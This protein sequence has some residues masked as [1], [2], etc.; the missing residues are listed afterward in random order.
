MEAAYDSQGYVF[1]WHSL[2][3]TVVLLG[4]PNGNDLSSRQLKGV[5]AGWATIAIWMKGL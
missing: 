2:V 5:Y 1:G 4:R 3:C